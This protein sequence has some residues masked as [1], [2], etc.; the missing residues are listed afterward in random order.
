MN[1]KKVDIN[2]ITLKKLM[3]EN[4]GRYIES[5]LYDDNKL[6]KIP[7]KI[8]MAYA[9]SAGLWMLFSDRISNIITGSKSSMLGVQMIKGGGYVLITSLIVYPLINEFT[10]KSK[11]RSYKLRK[12]YQDIKAACALL[13]DEKEELKAQYEELNK[14]RVIIGKSEER[15]KIAVESAN[16]AIWEID[17]V[18]KDFFCSDKFGDITG[19]DKD[20]ITSSDDL[21]KLVA[22]DDRNIAENDFNNH[23]NGKTVYY[24]SSIKLKFDGTT[25]R[26]VF[27]RGKC[28]R[29]KKGVAIKIL[30][31]ITDISAQ[32]D[33]EAKVNKLRYYDI[34]TDTL[35][36][37]SFINTLENEIIKAKHTDIKHAV[38]FIDLDNFKEIN[39]TLGHD[40]GDKLLK[41]VAILFKASIREGDLV[42]RVGG[43]E[44]FI[45][46]KNIE[47]NDQ[48][49]CLCERLQ[50]LLKSDVNVGDKQVYTSASIGITVLPDDGDQT[51]ILLKNADTALYSAKCNGKARYSFFNK[52]MSDVVLRRVEIEKGLRYA[53]KNNE[54]EIYYQPQIDIINNKIKGFEALLRW[55]SAELGR[56]NPT[57]FIPI[58]EQSGLL[59]PMGDWIIKTVCIQNNLW[60]SKGYLYDTIAINLS[61][62]QLENHRFEDNLKNLITETKI[63]PKFVELEITESVLMKD[64]DNNVKLLTGIRELGINIAL[65]DFGTGYSSLS[66][67]RHLP[68]NTLKID[69]SFIDNIVTNERERAILG[70]IIH[71]AQ[72]IDLNVVAEGAETKEQI[73]LLQKMGCNQIQGYYFSKPLPA[74]EIEEKFLKTNCIKPYN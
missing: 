6:D 39:E 46:M 4:E 63:D 71:L 70:G 12:G 56:M 2:K 55:N 43:D 49:S 28:Q 16:D 21:I 5:L 67:L 44:F 33:I 40:Y 74:G 32:K 64:F 10:K 13:I 58:A 52:S 61:A 29:D 45:L 38:L 31:T 50:N 26:W 15:Y 54:L 37:K 60:K 65:D 48:I 47:N 25:D 30:G 41:N 62:I 66:Y 59:I 35:N 8:T 69:K 53:M 73:N 36:R 34:L 17:L 19:C 18:T 7:L 42:S 27:I 1:E 14:K 9:L 3:S 24:K 22:Q 68:I 11:S 51:S 72:K 57:E 23:I 20:D